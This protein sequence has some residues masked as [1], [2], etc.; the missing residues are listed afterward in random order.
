[1]RNLIHKI[2]DF[3]YGIKND[4]RVFNLAKQAKFTSLK[5]DKS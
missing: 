5:R 2:I 4:A 1:M 3:Q